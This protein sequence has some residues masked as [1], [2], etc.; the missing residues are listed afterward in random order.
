MFPGDTLLYCSPPSPQAFSTLVKY[1]MALPI[2][3]NIATLAS[4][5]HETDQFLKYAESMKKVEVA[6]RAGTNFSDEMI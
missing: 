6:V 1:N 2:A 4:S 3:M 5:C